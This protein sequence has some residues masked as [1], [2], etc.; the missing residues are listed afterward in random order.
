M[1]IILFNI[2]ALQCPIQKCDKYSKTSISTSDISILNMIAYVKLTFIIFMYLSIYMY[3]I[4]FN[5]FYLMLLISLVKFLVP[6]S[7]RRGSVVVAV[8]LTNSVELYQTADLGQHYN[9][10]VYT[11]VPKL[12][13]NMYTSNRSGAG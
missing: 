6:V 2:L 8:A 5:S 4:Q 3:C 7:L 13:V 9:V 1:L 11:L 12:K 10:H